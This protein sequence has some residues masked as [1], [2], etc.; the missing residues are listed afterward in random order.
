METYSPVGLKHAPVYRYLRDGTL[1]GS[2]VSLY[3]EARQIPA[4]WHFQGIP[5]ASA[6]N[7]VAALR[8]TGVRGVIVG[9]AL[10]R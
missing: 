4:G 5:A 3:E 2:N 8:G 7:D 1:A 6:I 10:W 9:R